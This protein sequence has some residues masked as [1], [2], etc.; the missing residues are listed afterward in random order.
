M[1]TGSNI[2]NHQD[3]PSKRHRRVLLVPSLP[4]HAD[5]T[6]SMKPYKVSTHSCAV[7]GQKSE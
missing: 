7:S 3:L 6:N 4:A 2:A 5:Q 1:H